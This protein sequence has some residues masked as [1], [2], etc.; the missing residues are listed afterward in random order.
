MNFN[1]PVLNILSEEG[2]NRVHEYSLQ[3][4]KEVGIRVDSEDAR[5]L[6]NKC[7][8]IRHDENVYYFSP[9]IVNW[10]I[11]KAPSGIDVFN[12]LGERCFTLGNGQKDT[13]FGIGVTNPNYHDIEADE[14]VPFTRSHTRIAAGLCETLPGYDLL[15]TPGIVQ[16]EPL[17][18][19]DLIS[20]ADMLSGTTKPLSLLVSEDGQFE[21][22][23][24]M[25]LKVT[26]LPSDKPCIIPYF[27]PVT[28]LVIND[29]TVKKMLLTVRYGFPF[30]YS[31]YS[32]YGATT[33]ITPGGT[34]AILN[35][36]LLAGLVLSQLI[37]EGTP[38]VLGS[39]PASFDMKNMGTSYLPATNQMNAIC[40]E[41][42]DHYN[43]P[44]AGTSGSSNGWA[45]DVQS[46]GLLWL[47]HLTAV[48]GKTGLVPFVGGNFDSMV[49]SPELVVL[50]GQVIKGSREFAS[51][52]VLD[53]NSVNIREIKEVGPGGNFL[54]S[55][56][57]IQA[58]PDLRKRPAELWDNLTFEKW[59]QL[60]KPKA[61][62]ILR[63]KTLELINNPDVPDDH[64]EIR[65]LTEEFIN[66]NTSEL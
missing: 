62:N 48:C 21:K 59:E 49:F 3:I 66:I 50:S 1:K 24:E 35:A 54:T 29:S 38:V 23:L 44:H 8:E 45:G 28:P 6:F 26:G 64:E 52:F 2:I 5:E 11:G 36:E 34:I 63:E 47:N 16:E 22:V 51:E 37:R 33:P 10:A 31:N 14:I 41:M 40:A 46:A 4:L 13:V 56:Q 30:I 19:T 32:M 27:N 7:E 43:I 53:D 15:S 58:L 61:E 57:T 18:S 20:T 12:R 17:S 39:L 9:Q 25:V 60:D 55:N 65:L 42:M